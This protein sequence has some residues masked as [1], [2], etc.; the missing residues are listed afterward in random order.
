VD[1]ETAEHDAE[2]FECDECPV[3]AALEDLDPFN[4]RVWELYKQVVTRLSADL[5]A[6]G[7]VLQ[8]LTQD[9]SPDEFAETWR[10]LVLL[11]NTIDPPPDPQQE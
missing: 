2:M 4:T 3:A 1:E 9:L 5:H 6:G 10:R 11:Y 7:I 8:A